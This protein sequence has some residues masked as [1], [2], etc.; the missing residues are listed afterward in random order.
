MGAYFNVLHVKNASKLPKDLNLE[1]VASMMVSLKL[2]T[3]QIQDE[4][5]CG[6]GAATAMDD[7]ARR[8]Q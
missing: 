8:I 5:E 4:V 3:T 2:S 6:E 7:A 1:I